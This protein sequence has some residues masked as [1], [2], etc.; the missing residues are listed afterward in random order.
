[1][2]EN[3]KQ[4]LMWEDIEGLEITVDFND[5]FLKWHHLIFKIDDAIISK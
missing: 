1:M 4:N 2:I 3:V 5:F